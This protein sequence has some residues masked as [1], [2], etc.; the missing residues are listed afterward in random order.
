ML[1][2]TIEGLRVLNP[3]Y[4]AKYEGRRTSLVACK[5]VFLSSRNRAGKAEA[6]WNSIIRRAEFKE[7]E[8]L[9][10]SKC[11]GKCLSPG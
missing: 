2:N 9:N 3:N 7:S 5:D 4:I 11:L 6:G 1:T 8:T 10:Q